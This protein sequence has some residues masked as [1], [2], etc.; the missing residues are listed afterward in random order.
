MMLLCVRQGSTQMGPTKRETV[1]SLAPLLLHHKQKATAWESCDGHV[2]HWVPKTGLF[3]KY[4]VN[5]GQHLLSFQSYRGRL[6]QGDHVPEALGT[7][8]QNS[9]SQL[10]NLQLV[11]LPHNAN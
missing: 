1:W 5:L 6:G 7:F 8:Q 10:L 2:S 3:N 9:K 4:R 11:S